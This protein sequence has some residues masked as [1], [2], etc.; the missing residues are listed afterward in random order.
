MT[1]STQV[2]GKTLTFARGAWV[3]LAVFYLGAYLFRVPL[4]L[5]ETP[6]F[7]SMEAGITQAEFL[8][9]LAQLGIS[10]SGYTAYHQW[11]SVIGPLIYLALGLFIFW[12][13]SNDWMAILTSLNVWS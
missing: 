7:T 6:Q 1:S 10:P 9:G 5:T 2:H 3:V 13:K 8:N 4:K 11:S 12:R